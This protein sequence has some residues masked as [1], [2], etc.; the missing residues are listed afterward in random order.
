VEDGDPLADDDLL[1]TLAA[2]EHD[3]WSHWQRY[4]HDQ[5]RHQDNGSLVIPAELA[6]R[7]SR[8]AS[9]AYQDL[10]EEEKESDREQVSRYLP[11]I[12]HALRP[13][14]GRDQ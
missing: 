13:S 8:Q 10:S 3:R 7:W 9:T 11:V 14:A 2:L 1:E 6:R 5:C 12:A 4:L